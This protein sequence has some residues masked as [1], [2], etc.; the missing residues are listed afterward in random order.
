VPSACSSRGATPDCPRGSVTA[1]STPHPTTMPTRS[2][3][4]GRLPRRE[5]ARVAAG[6]RGG[7]EQRRASRT[8][9]NRCYRC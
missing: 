6:A 8:A 4:G 7:G 1:M 2:S 5:G 9:M 3:A